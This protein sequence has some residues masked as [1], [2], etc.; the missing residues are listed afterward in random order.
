LR[1]ACLFGLCL[2]LGCGFLPP[3]APP[4]YA[5]LPRCTA[6]LHCAYAHAG[7]AVHT[8]AC[9]ATGFSLPWICM[10]TRAS[11]TALP[12]RLGYPPAATA[13]AAAC[14]LP[15]PGHRRTFALIFTTR[16]AHRLPAVLPGCYRRFCLPF[17]PAHYTAP[18]FLRYATFLLYLLLVYGSRAARG[19]MPSALLRFCCRI[20]VLHR[21]CLPGLPVGLRTVHTTAHHHCHLP[22]RI[23]LPAFVRSLHYGYLGYCHRL[24]LPPAFAQFCRTRL[25]AH[26]FCNTCL[27]PPFL[28]LPALQFSA[29]CTVLH[30][31]HLRYCCTHCR[32]LWMHGFTAPAFSLPAACLPRTC[33]H[34]PLR[35]PPRVPHSA[36]FAPAVLPLLGISHHLPARSG[37]ATAVLPP[38]GS[39]PGPGFTCHLDYVLDPVLVHSSTPSI[40]TPI[41][42]ACSH[43]PACL[44]AT[45]ILPATATTPPFGGSTVTCYHR[46]P[47]RFSTVPAG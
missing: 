32:I 45:A 20:P 19:C 25:P 27:P 16:T 37:S 40:S 1:F 44:P 34:L 17:T 24:G 26:R 42:T 13:P 46:L 22:L 21:A 11:S 9:A 41:P 12:A 8:A 31:P 29:F 33:L 6:V 14:L 23:T 36:D 10:R 38:A 7:S 39:A 2:P 35:I 43:L 30:L 4:P 15:L 5:L 18:P 47:A 28:P 3:A